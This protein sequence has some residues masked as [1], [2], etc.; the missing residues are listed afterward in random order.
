MIANPMARKVSI[1]LRRLFRHD[2]WFLALLILAFVFTF[3]FVV[4][5]LFRVLQESYLVNGRYSLA[6]YISLLQDST[7]ITVLRNSLWLGVS[8]GLVSTLLGFAYAYVLSR[9]RVFFRRGL[10]LLALLPIVT[11]PFSI[12]IAA[13]LLFGRAGLITFKLLGIRTGAFYGYWGLLMVQSLSLAPVA[14]LVLVGMLRGINPFLEEAAYNM[15]ASSWQIFRTVT[16]P[17]MRPGLANAF[18]LSFITSLADF[19]NPMVIGGNF[20]VLAPTIYF[21]IVGRYDFGSAATLSVILLFPTL[22]AFLLQKFWIG[23]KQYITVTGKP[24]SRLGASTCKPVLWVSAVITLF[25][26]IAIVAFY[27][28]VIAGGL[29]RTWGFDFT[30][31]L[32]HYQF[33][34]QVG[35]RALW[36][37]LLL[38]LVSTPLAATFGL[39][40]AYLTVR[41]QFRL[42]STLEFSTILSFAVPGTVMGIGYVLAF[43]SG[44]IVLTGT[45]SIIVIA[46]VFR[47][48]SVSIR[49]GVASLQQVDRSME[50]AAI[51]MGANTG[52]VLLSIVFPLIKSSFL[53]GMIYSFVRAM[54]AISST[55]F[56]VSPKWPLVVP[57]ILNLLDGARMGAAAAY[58]TIMIVLIVAVIA[59]LNKLFGSESFSSS[60]QA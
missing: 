40:V 18:L 26:S 54:T 5:P 50:E 12:G 25:W 19:G 11:P 23:K 39:V 45:A 46:L 41:K 33:L 35:F 16:W 37:T 42:R 52:R 38:S 8:A 3:F 51:N 31:S 14:Y 13:I 44:L 24:S 9:P 48:M 21:Y 20:R 32:Q 43:N 59:I 55:V 29:V 49:S 15:G 10:E 6:R 27:A 57:T 1:R 30:F 56:L 47:N 58:S 4:Y 36:N 34:W 28:A 7:V 22:G 60:I 17:L 2:P 53:A